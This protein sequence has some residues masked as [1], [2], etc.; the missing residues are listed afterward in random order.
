MGYTWPR[1]VF[2][3][4]FER[5]TGYFYYMTK[6]KDEKNLDIDVKLNTPAT[7]LITDDS[8]AVTGVV[9]VADDGTTY[10]IH[11]A[12]G[13]LL[14]TGGFS[15]N[16]E[17][18][19]KYDTQ[20]GIEAG[21]QVKHDNSPGNTGDGIRMAEAVGAA[22]DGMENIMMFPMGSVNDTND[23]SGVGIF[24][25][26]SNLFVNTKGERFVDETASRFEICHAVFA[27]EVP[28]DF[29]I[30]DNLNSGLADEDEAA[31][32]KA[33]EHGS[34]YRG[35]TIAELAEAMGVEPATLEATV[36]QYNE[37]CKTYHDELFGRATF[38]DGSEIV[39]APFYATPQN[40]VA[41]ITIGGIVTDPDG[42][43]LDAEGN[44]IP[45]LYAAGETV[46]GS[47]GISAFA[48]GRAI[49]KNMVNAA[50]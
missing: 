5:G 11:S 30:T 46:N 35:N 4:G 29:V 15:A 48:Y 10:R 22:L 43:V 44:A 33:I 14:A 24:N 18:L 50:R 41:H 26:S 2:P 25:G 19:A 1:W 27:Q 28:M 8:G 7:E 16:S 40:P 42:H 3:D 36:A 39:E 17:M 9:A 12:H 32:Q 47:C 38:A 31:I 37:A 49:A 6:Y 20:W 45:G 21:Q 23:V 34:L 13:V